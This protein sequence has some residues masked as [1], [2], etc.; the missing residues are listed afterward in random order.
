MYVYTYICIY[1]HVYAC[2]YVCMCIYRHIYI[3]IYIYTYIIERHATQHT[4]APKHISPRRALKA[5]TQA[6][7]VQQKRRQAPIPQPATLNEVEVQHR[8][9]RAPEAKLKAP[10]RQGLNPQA[11]QSLAT[12]HTQNSANLHRSPR[13]AVQ[14]RWAGVRCSPFAFMC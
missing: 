13:T 14:R 9:T 2:M 3:Y 10:K 11:Q 8:K 4:R 1:A 6:L 5:P 7:E 12:R